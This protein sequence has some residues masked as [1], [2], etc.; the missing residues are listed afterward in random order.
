MIYKQYSL[1]SGIVTLCRGR[2][3]F[4]GNF[5]G[6]QFKGFPN[7]HGLVDTG[8]A[9]MSVGEFSY[10]GKVGPLCVL[11]LMLIS[12]Q[13]LYHFHKYVDECTVLHSFR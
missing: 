3:P 5:R 7:T 2:P 13:S 8:F 12:E 9:Q 4:S 1:Y 6:F 10:F 11:A